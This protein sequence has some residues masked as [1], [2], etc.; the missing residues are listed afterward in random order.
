MRW[1]DGKSITMIRFEFPKNFLWGTATSSFQIEGGADA[2]GRGPS[3]W[4][5]ACRQY[6]EKFL[7]GATPEVST[8]FYH[9]YPQDVAMMKELGLKSFRF[10]ISWSRIFPT[11]RGA[12][13]AKGLE[14]YDR[15]IDTLLAH[16]IEPHSQR[17]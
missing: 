6:P 17:R 10:S 7:H 5:A 15:L 11:G 1:Q 8:D 13:N 4:D 14:F 3:M 9:R 2:D 16:Q 12:V